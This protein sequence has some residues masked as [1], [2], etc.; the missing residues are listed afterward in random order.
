LTGAG[1][2]AVLEL[3]C[4][5]PLLPVQC[6]HPAENDET[7]GQS[8]AVHCER[9]SKGMSFAMST[10]TLYACALPIQNNFQNAECS[11]ARSLSAKP[12]EIFV[13]PARSGSTRFSVCRRMVVED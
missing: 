1:Q 12:V 6:Q 13:V 10:A 3:Y 7:D 2:P 8:Q 9:S 5:P 11:A 4:P